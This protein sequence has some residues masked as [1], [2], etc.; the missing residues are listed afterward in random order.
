MSVAADAKSERRY[1]PMATLELDAALLKSQWELCDRVSEYLSR[2][3]GQIHGDPARYSNFLAVTVNEL[4]ELAFKA[5]TEVGQVK[6]ELDK[7][8]GCVRVKLSF[9]CP[10]DTQAAICKEIGGTINGEVVARRTSGWIAKDVDRLARFADACQ[11]ELTAAE[12]SPNRIA[13]TAAFLWQE[14]LA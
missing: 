8:P 3:V 10:E 1:G 9:D 5:S 12:V 4:V 2:I 6:F 13:L 11:V 7:E 14:E